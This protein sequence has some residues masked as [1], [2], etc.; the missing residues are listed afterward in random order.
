MAIRRKA[1][2]ELSGFDESFFMYFEDADLCYRCGKAGWEVHFTPVATIVHAGG[3]S[4]DRVREE[5]AAQLLQS[6]ALFYER[7]S[8]RSNVVLMQ[9][10]VKCLMFAKWVGSKG[11]LTFTRDVEKCEILSDRIAACEKVLFA[12]SQYR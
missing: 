12:K 5:M 7:H 11:C 2:D 1:F 8:S 9:I 10:I 3:A 6:T 4:T